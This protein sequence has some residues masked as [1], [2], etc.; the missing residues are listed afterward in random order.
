MD[1]E[2]CNQTAMTSLTFALEGHICA[3]KSSLLLNLPPSNFYHQVLEPDYAWRH[4]NYLDPLLL[5]YQDPK[6]NGLALQCL[7]LETTTEKED[8]PNVPL[9]IRER[10]FA[11]S[12]FVFTETL[13]QAN[14]ISILGYRYLED[15]YNKI[16][17]TQ[18]IT[19]SVYLH[20]NLETIEARIQKRA[21]SEI[22]GKSEY[23]ALLN[24]VQENYF[25]KQIQAKAIVLIIDAT[26]DE[27]FVRALF[28]YF[29][30]CCE[31]CKEPATIMTFLNLVKSEN[32]K[33]FL[34][35]E[36]LAL[37]LANVTSSASKPAKISL[38]PNEIA[39][40]NKG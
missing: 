5:F 1:G 17:H 39:T 21:T 11:S 23:F 40:I 7:I 16:L 38:D 3:G 10:S 8:L 36:K 24:K 14:Y 9:L 4:Y 35:F 13:F 25:E 26:I 34:T 6:S 33:D 30:K 15:R 12:L 18:P 32:L 22:Y 37:T 27:N 19:A 2:P 28:K 29:I 31:I 20:T